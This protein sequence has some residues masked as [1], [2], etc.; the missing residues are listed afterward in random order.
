MFKFPIMAASDPTEQAIDLSFLEKRM[1]AIR[2][3]RPDE[4]PTEP[5]TCF[6]GAILLDRPGL[7]YFDH[8]S[9]GVV[10]PDRPDVRFSFT[11]FGNG[12]RPDPPFLTRVKHAGATP[13]FGV[14]RSGPRDV[15][16]N[17][18]EEHLERVTEENGTISHLF[19]WEAQGL[20]C[21]FDRPQ[22]ILVMTTGNGQD[23]PVYASLSDKDALNL[24][25]AVLTSLR[26]R[27]TVP[28]TQPKP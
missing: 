3:R 4:I 28:A 9:V 2:F 27:P 18:G 7:D 6:D 17:A 20:P 12:P 16:G 23:G 10:W 26:W 15:D 21:R 13:L 1:E 22:L 11:V 19:H 5:G 8:V 14:L 25:D 24:W